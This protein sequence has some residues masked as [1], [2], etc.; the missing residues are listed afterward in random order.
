MQAPT[1]RLTFEEYCN[2]DNGDRYELVNGELVE[3]PLARGKHALI[4]DALNDI[5]KAQIKQMGKDWISLHSSIGVRIPQVG[6][7]DT[8]RIPD[9][10]VVTN[11]QWHG[12]LDK[13]AVLEDSPPLLVVEVVSEGTQIID[14]RRKRAEYN[15]VEIPE[16]WVIDFIANSSTYPPGVKVLT[17]IEGFY[18]EAVFRGDEQIVSPTFPELALTAKQILLEV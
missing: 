16:Y 9:I 8:S 11:A 2:L 4:V 1:G 18:E 17:L 3:M 13:S 15:I 10:C 14:H 5:F 12:L 7:R 6:R